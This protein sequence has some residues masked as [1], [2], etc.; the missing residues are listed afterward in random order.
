MHVLESRIWLDIGSLAMHELH[1]QY[2]Y[3][4]Q[5]R[6]AARL[7]AALYLFVSSLAYD[8]ENGVEMLGE[9]TGSI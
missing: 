2:A 3:H 9:K 5:Q 4:G 8:V 1:G 6:V 7:C